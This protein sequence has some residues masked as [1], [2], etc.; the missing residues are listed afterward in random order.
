MNN[1]SFGAS[2][3]NI[4]NKKNM[5]LR[6]VEIASGGL[7]SSFIVKKENYILDLRLEGTGKHYFF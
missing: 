5:S 7:S 3:K 1:Q 6:Q 2:I 4:R